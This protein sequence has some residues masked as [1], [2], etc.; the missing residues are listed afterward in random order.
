MATSLKHVQQAMQQEASEAVQTE[1]LFAEDNFTPTAT[2]IASTEQ[3]YIV[4]R[5]VNKKQKRL[6]LDGICHDVLNPNTGNYET[7]RLIR[8]KSSIWTSELTED[9]KDKDYINKNRIGLQFLDGICRIGAKE[10]TKLEYARKHLSNVGKV[11]NGAGKYDFYEYDAAEEQ[12]MRYAKRM[13]R[14]NLIQLISTMEENKMI[15]LAQFLGVKPYDDEVGLPKIPSGYRTELLIKADTQPEIV[16]KNINSIEVE[17]AYMVRKAIMDAKIDLTGQTGNAIW[18]GAGGFIAKI[19]S[20]R[21]SVEY[22][23]ELAMT[24]SAEGK[25]FKQQLE[26]IVT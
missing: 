15:K 1:S 23:T 9:L 12:Q 7:I 24:N 25:Q 20:G 4:F 10:K 13:E 26:Q 5:L 14:I 8:G 18:A 22:L 16:S 17:I 3:Q 21:K 19:P 2:A 11:R 6:T